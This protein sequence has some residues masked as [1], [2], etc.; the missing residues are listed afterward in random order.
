MTA[1]GTSLVV[2]RLVT[3][4]GGLPIV[5]GVDLAA[6]PGAVTVV[7]GPNGCGKS[8]TMR[9]I[10]GLLPI[11]DGEVRLV[12]RGS[13]VQLAGLSPPQRLAA[14]LSYVPQ[15]RT[16]FPDMSVHENLVLGGWLW[17]RDR[18]E[19]ARRLAHVYAA[20]PM[21]KEW[22]GRQLGLL[23]GGQQ[24]LVEIGR[25][26]VSA[27]GVLILD[28][29]TAGVSPAAVDD[30][31]VLLRSIADREGTAVLMVEQNLEA[32]LRVAD[33]AYCLVAGHNSTDG[34]AAQILG[35]LPG[36]VES[37]LWA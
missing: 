18:E 10:G 5:D 25:A 21:L 22:G 30:L 2:R 20:L 33:H 11:D 24:K 34:P 17:R 36:I 29:P 37:W 13:A 35:R 4:Y 15:E 16:G 32:A 14:G 12:R 7:I 27:P 26:L 6:A 3:G 31:L 8:T 19:L 23:S 9:A 28:E 1:D